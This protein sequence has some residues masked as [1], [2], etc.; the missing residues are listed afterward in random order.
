MLIHRVTSLLGAQQSRA[1]LLGNRRPRRDTG[2]AQAIT[3]NPDQRIGIKEGFG[4]SDNRVCMYCTVYMPALK[5]AGANKVGKHEIHDACVS[6]FAVA[7][8]RFSRSL[9][10]KNGD[11]RTIPAASL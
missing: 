6:V 11:T 1:N 3:C 7:S 2:S 4:A 9:W 8:S 5:K 10:G